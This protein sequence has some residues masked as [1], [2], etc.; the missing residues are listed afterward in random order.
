MTPPKILLTA[1]EPSGDDIGA[2]LI[3]AIRAR[4]PEASFIGCG[5]AAM[6]REGLQS[7]FDIAPL[8]VMGF[9][10]VARAAPKAFQFADAIAETVVKEKPDIAVLVDGW[11]FSRLVA[12]R[13]KKFSPGTTLVKLAAPQVWASRAGR[14]EFVKSH[15]DA[16]LCLLPF[17][18]PYF[19]KAG[20]KAE[21]I[22]NPNFQAA[23][24]ARGDGAGFRARHGLGDA[25]VL[26]VLLGS[27]RTEVNRLA[28]PFGEAVQLLAERV[29]GLRVAAPLAPSVDRLARLKLSRFAG[30]PI[31]VGPA[32]KNDAMA[33]ANVG[34]TA[35]GTASTELAINR[36]PMVVGYK[37][38]PITAIWARSVLRTPYVSIINVA[39]GRPVI[40]ELLQDEC[41][42]PNLAGALLPLFTDPHVYAEQGSAFSTI[43]KSLGVDGAPAADIAAARILEWASMGKER[44]KASP[45]P[46]SSGLA[47]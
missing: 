2:S 33:A 37:L 12:T 32:E 16:V 5:G 25:P 24:R 43:L 28:K 26:A 7:L 11:A 9:L 27:R 15:F 30:D 44:L 39:G 42:G 34:L 41:K 17:E 14:V 45:R 13:L 29:P 35:S 19:T 4:A 23:W 3:A 8:S 22:G 36:T 21:F 46:R 31:L 40:P 38:D 18:P 6:S 10:D 47:L 1:V 20:V